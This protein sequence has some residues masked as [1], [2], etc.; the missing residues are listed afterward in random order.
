MKASPSPDIVIVGAGPAGLAAAIAAREKGLRV[1]ATDCARPPIDKTCG[2]GLMPDG[3]AALEKL[4]IA[5]GPEH[6]FPFR[7]I[8]FLGSGVTVDSSFP[9][10]CGIGVRRTVLH[11]LLIDRAE[12][13][14]VSLLWGARVSGLSEQGVIVDGREIPCRW[15]IGADGEN[16]RVRR[17][18]GLD[19][20]RHDRRRYGFRRHYRVAPWTD[21]MEIY[22]G[23]GCQLYVTPV[24]CHS[25]CVALISRDPRLRLDAAVPGFPDLAGRLEFAGPATSERGAISPSRALTR[26]VRGRVAL[27]GDASGSVDAITGEG[28]CLSFHQAIALAGALASGDPAAYESRHRRLSRRPAF[29]S[30][31][32]LSLDRLPWLRAR[33]LPALASNPSIFSALLAMHVGRLPGM[34][35]TDL[36]GFPPSGEFSISADR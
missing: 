15:V 6:G 21:C 2:E 10:G 23:D 17:W 28:L 32:M 9:S 19:R 33:V 4:G 16:S 8:R 20:S 34:C 1:T 36:S 3:L 26:V 30:S 7:G 29:M 11:Q 12:Q 31:L 22:W 13:A 18:A 27:I 24:D 25:V 35:K 5:I 14:G